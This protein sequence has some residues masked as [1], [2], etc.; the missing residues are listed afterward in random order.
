MSVLS[1]ALTADVSTASGS[2]QGSLAAFSASLM[3]ASITFWQLAVGEHD[4]AEHDLFRKLLGFGFDHHHRI[5]GAGDDEVELAFLDLVHRRVELIFAVLVADAGGGDRAHEGNARNGQR[6]RSGDHRQD[7][8]LG[9]AVI[10]QH[11]RDHVDLVAEPSGN[12]G[13]IGRSIR[14]LVS[15]SF[16]VAPR[17]RLKKPPGMRPAAENFS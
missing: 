16:S 14:R 4:G 13:R 3:I 8:A 15:V 7:V 5:V 6:R 12:S 1:L 17:S 9:L 10:G 2:S 11:L